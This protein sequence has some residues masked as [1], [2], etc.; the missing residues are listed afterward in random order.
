MNIT[1]YDE[2]NICLASDSYKFGHYKFYMPNTERIYSYLEARKGAKFN[3]VLFYGL[4]YV[5][6]KYLVGKVVTK[7]RI[8]EAERII[9]QHLGKGVFNRAGWEYILEKHDGHLPVLIKA[10][11]EGTLVDVD[12]ALMTV[13]NTD[14][15][16]PWLTNY[17]ETI[18][19]QTWYA[20]T[21]ATN[22]YETRLLIEDYYRRTGSDFA[23][24]D[25]A[26]HGFGMRACTSFEA[27]GIADS[28]HLIN[29]KGTDT[30]PAL[31]FAM[32]WYGAKTVPGFSVA[33]TEHSIMTSRMEDGEWDV[34]ENI[35][36]AQ[37][38][39]ILSVVI[40]SYNWE[41]FVD[42]CGTKYKDEILARDGKFVFRPDSGD[43]VT[44][45]I[46]ILGKLEQYFGVSRNALGYK[47]LNAKVGVLWGDGIGYSG[48][49]NVLFA[50]KNAGWAAQ[51]I[52]FG[53]GG[54]MVQSG[55]ERDTMRFAF[56]CS[57]T[58]YDGEWHDV[59]KRPLD[60]T[61]A[62]KRGRLRV[63]RVTGQDGTSF[64]KT[65]RREEADYDELV[66]VFRDGVLI[67]EYTFDEIRK[68]VELY[69][70]LGTNRNVEER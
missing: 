69:K 29:F 14:P 15:N 60:R 40:D 1:Q 23:G 34:F 51:N 57:A 10:I 11:P 49:R 53:M 70:S 12:N 13:V 5:L 46:E 66:T 31:T 26:L 18:L 50:M 24:I 33:A 63:I 48:V 9:D 6:K 16:V 55:L 68:N 44:V 3:K 54:H 43:A 47:V 62:S 7:K 61:K 59:Y 65:L 42:T 52:V 19:M 2:N 35:L 36:R 4:Q 22:D 27:C 32:N 8:D 25:F 41:R 17:L 30:V 45:T 20:M 37:P 39:G 38:T 64:F 21:V 56:K 67:K 58:Q 28:A